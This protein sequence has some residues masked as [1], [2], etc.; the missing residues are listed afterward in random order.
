MEKN[1]NRSLVLY[2]IQSKSRFP[3]RSDWVS[4]NKRS[5]STCNTTIFNFSLD[6]NFKHEMPLIHIMNVSLKYHVNKVEYSV[7]A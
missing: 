1:L 4:G 5:S 3:E 2:L 7:D 6:F